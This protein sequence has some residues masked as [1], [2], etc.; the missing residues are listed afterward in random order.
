VNGDA[1]KPLCVFADPHDPAPPAGP[2]PSVIY[3]GPGVHHAGNISVAA[4]QSVYLAGGA[5]VH[6][7]VIGEEGNCDGVAVRGRGVL[8]GHELPICTSQP[9]M[10]ELSNCRDVTVE[11]IVTVDSPFYQIRSYAPGAT[12]RF[13]KAIAWGFSTDGWS[14]GQY[15][16]VE[17]CFNKVNDDATKLYRT[18]SVVQ[19][20]VYWQMENGC[21]FMMSWNTRENV[22]YVAARDN[23]VIA[24]ER[25]GSWGGPDG[26]ICAVHG[27]LG[28]LNDYL[29]DGLRVEGAQWGLVSIA[30]RRNNW[31]PAAGPIGS[32]STLLL[33]NVSIAAPLP[34]PP[35]DAFH[36]AGNASEHAR[37]DTV[38]YDGV[39][40]GGVRLT[41]AQ[42]RPGVGERASNVTVCVGCSAELVPYASRGWTRDQICGRAPQP[43][44][45]GVQLPPLA[46]PGMSP[47]CD[48]TAAE[49]V[50]SASL[51]AHTTTVYGVRP[52]GMLGLADK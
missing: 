6:G 13:A 19:R 24:H 40:I 26:V 20:G 27:G 30:M 31:S 52:R 45:D 16:L 10:L 32:I 5:H 48:R 42:V 1:D 44:I 25:T 23:D 46:N 4:G 12:I 37:V 9:A 51:T 15:S 7:Q 49:P 14:G 2:S 43:Y 3:F 35:A 39:T 18:G 34:A 28:N 17:D 36:V 29:F 33:R 22:G 21:P 38:I 8:D 47:Y 11:G 50:P 41:D